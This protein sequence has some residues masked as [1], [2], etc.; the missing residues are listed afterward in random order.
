LAEPDLPGGGPPGSFDYHATGWAFDIPR[1]ADDGQ[2]KRLEY[3]LG[4]LRDRDILWFM[5]EAEYGPRRYHVVPNPVYQADL[6]RI[7]KGGALP[8]FTAADISTGRISRPSR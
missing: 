3:A 7:G 5:Q 1:P 2:R 8:P 6:T 4:F